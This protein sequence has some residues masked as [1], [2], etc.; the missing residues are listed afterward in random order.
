MRG[1][2]PAREAREGRA[3]RGEDGLVV[4]WWRPISKSLMIMLPASPSNYLIMIGKCRPG[5]DTVGSLPCKVWWLWAAPRRLLARD[6]GM[7]AAV[8]TC[9][10]AHMWLQW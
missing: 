3:A 10:R 1:R 5:A 8:M 4:A 2:A 7:Q 6:G 9:G